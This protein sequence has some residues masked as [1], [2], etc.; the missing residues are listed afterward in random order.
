MAARN[1]TIS[2]GRL[3]GGRRTA[4]MFSVPTVVNKSGQPAEPLCIWVCVV[5]SLWSAPDK[6]PGSSG[7]PM[8]CKRGILAM[9]RINLLLCLCL[10]LPACSRGARDNADSPPAQVRH[11][12]DA[13]V[14]TILDDGQ[15]YFVTPAR[16]LK[17]RSF[18]LYRCISHATYAKMVAALPA[19]DV[20]VRGVCTAERE[21]YPLI[22]PSIDVPGGAD[23]QATIRLVGRGRPPGNPQ[24]TAIHFRYFFFRYRAVWRGR[25][26]IRKR[27]IVNFV[28]N[29]RGRYMQAWVMLHPKS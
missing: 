18:P 16:Y 7:W 15:M 6:A 9:T 2:E 28:F 17:M 4:S 1:K 26:L 19:G 14:I 3:H 11:G 27:G 22:S 12:P 20:V 8:R 24:A 23:A 5:K 29:R 13:V 25:Y 10:I 21:L